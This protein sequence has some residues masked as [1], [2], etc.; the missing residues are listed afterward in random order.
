[1]IKPNLT[2]PRQTQTV[3]VKSECHMW[4]AVKY[5]DPSLHEEEFYPRREIPRKKSEVMFI[6]D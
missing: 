4:I 1:M 2:L 5:A 3:L 6:N